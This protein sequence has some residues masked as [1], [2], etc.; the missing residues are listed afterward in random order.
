M[1]HPNDIQRDADINPLFFG[2]QK[3]VFG[4]IGK[5]DA[6]ISIAERAR[7]SVNPLPSEHGQFVSPKVVPERVVA[8]VRD[9]GIEARLNR[10]PSLCQA[11]GASERGDIIVWI[12]IAERFP[13]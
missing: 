12:R 3:G 6:L 13:D 10:M 2:G 4:A 9:T 1:R 11:D 8:L 5:S 7:I